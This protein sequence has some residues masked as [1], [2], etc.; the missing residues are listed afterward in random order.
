MDRLFLVV[1]LFIIVIIFGEVA[2]RGLFLFLF[3][4]L[5]FVVQIVRDDVQVNGMY[6][7][8]FEFGF[9]LR[10][11]ENLALFDFVFVHVDF[12]GTFGAADHVYILRTVVDQVGA[13]RAVSTTVERIIYRG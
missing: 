9:A 5:F 2:I 10:A 11:A 1:F 8:H 3:F 13:T 6:L 7:R 4:V 12:G